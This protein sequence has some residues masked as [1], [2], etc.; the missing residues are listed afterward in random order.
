[1]NHLKYNNQFF[2]IIEVYM[3]R[4]GNYNLFQIKLIFFERQIIN[5]YLVWILSRMIKKKI[6][7]NTLKIEVSKLSKYNE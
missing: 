3:K 4:R 5:M 2:L 7:K 6:P 1:M